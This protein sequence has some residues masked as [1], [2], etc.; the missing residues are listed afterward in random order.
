M[1]VA[2]I[3]GSTGLVGSRILAILNENPSITK[4]HSLSRRPPLAPKTAST[5]S[6]AETKLN[7]LTLADSSEWPLELSTV[8]PTPTIFFSALGTTKAAAGS[9]AIQRQID[10]ELNLSLAKSAKEIDAKVYVLISS[11]GANSKSLLPYPKMKGELEDAVQK[12]GFKT[13]VIL[14]PGLLL[15]DRA[16]SRPAEW[17]VRKFAG[18]VGLL[19]QGATDFWAQDAAVVAQAAVS[20]GLT[21]LK[22]DKGSTWE[23]TQAD[24][25][26]MGRHEEQNK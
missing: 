25:V 22:E 14:R 12:L 21:A 10:Y 13:V 5:N 7:S 1:T 15:G 17:A 11:A 9:V 26:K 23:L 16:E 8:T 4:I 18:I 19:G 3:V 6:L 2:G 20:A 24:I